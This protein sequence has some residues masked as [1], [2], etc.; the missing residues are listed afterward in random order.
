MADPEKESEEY[1]EQHYYPM[2]EKKE[3]ENYGLNTNLKNPFQVEVD[4]LCKGMN[5]VPEGA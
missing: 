5:I 4:F 3:T 1:I 2:R